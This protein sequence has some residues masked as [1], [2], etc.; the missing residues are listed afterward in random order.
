[1]E[2]KEI[3]KKIDTLLSLKSGQLYQN[4][5]LLTWDKREDEIR[6]VLTVAEILQMMREQNISPRIFDSGLAVAI[7]RDKSTRTRFS[8]SLSQPIE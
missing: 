1:M 4:D 3:Q 2:F 7:F 8:F 5:F 6:A